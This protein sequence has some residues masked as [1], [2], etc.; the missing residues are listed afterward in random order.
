MDRKL[1]IQYPGAIYHV[2]NRGDNSEVIF[3]ADKDRDLFLTT[4]ADACGKTDWI[5][6]AWCLMS[7]HFHF[8]VETPR[9]NLVPGMKWLLGT[10]TLR[11]NRRHKLSGHLFSG[12]YKAL[13]VEGS[14]NGLPENSL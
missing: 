13:V 5:V 1:R 2:I 11:F 4:L 10:Y 14:G 3:R 6:H 9:A 12:R 7:N 8:V